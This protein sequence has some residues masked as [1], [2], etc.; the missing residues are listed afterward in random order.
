MAADAL[1]RRQE[2]P[3]ALRQRKLV[4][5]GLGRETKG[6]G[7]AES[8]RPQAA[9]KL[10]ETGGGG[11]ERRGEGPRR[12]LCIGE[13]RTLHLIVVAPVLGAV[14]GAG[15]IIEGGFGVGAAKCR[16]N[17]PAV[18]TLSSEAK[19]CMRSAEAWQLRQ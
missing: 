17:M 19:V 18:S 5:E 16:Y 9:V 3:R 4:V 7:V 8:V 14:L 1:I 6:E 2:R 12:S 13:R 15:K 10:R 11:A